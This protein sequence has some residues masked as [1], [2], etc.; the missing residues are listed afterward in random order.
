MVFQQ[1]YKRQWKSVREERQIMQSQYKKKKFA[2][3]ERRFTLGGFS[4]NLLSE[5]LNKGLS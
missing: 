5:T 1:V 4:L 3:V 2:L